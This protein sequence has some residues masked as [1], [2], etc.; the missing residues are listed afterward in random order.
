MSPTTNKATFSPQP[1]AK[2]FGWQGEHA[3]RRAS[4]LGTPPRAQPSNGLEPGRLS[5]FEQGIHESFDHRARTAAVMVGTYAAV[6]ALQHWSA[7]SRQQRE[8]Q[9]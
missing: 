7:W 6:R 8:A 4:Q 9:R 2:P 3:A 1:M 5:D